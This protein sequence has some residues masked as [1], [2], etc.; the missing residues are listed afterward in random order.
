MDQ[1]L[2][3]NVIE[4][5]FAHYG[6][7]LIIHSLI[8]HDDN[9]KIVSSTKEQSE[10]MKNYFNKILAL[11]N[12]TDEKTQYNPCPM[13]TPFTKKEINEAAEGLRNGKNAEIDNINNELIKYAA[14]DIHAQI[15]EIF[16]QMAITGKL[17]SKIKT[18]ISTPLQI[19]GKKK[20]PY[21]L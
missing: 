2:H 4:L 9:K 10:I 1:Q 21:Y 16:N 3:G 20:G 8:I 19:L 12:I 5:L 17:P 6:P 14:N 7:L 11:E 15:A 13:S 18:G